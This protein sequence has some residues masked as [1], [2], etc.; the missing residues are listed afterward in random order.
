MCAES[1][2]TNSYNVWTNNLRY[3]LW[4]HYDIYADCLQ[5]NDTVN[6][7]DT[8]DDESW[9]YSCNYDF[10]LLIAFTCIITIFFLIW[11]EFLLWSLVYNANACF[12]CSATFLQGNDGVQQIHWGIEEGTKY[13]VKRC[14]MAG[15]RVRAFVRKYGE[16]P[17]LPPRFILSPWKQPLTT[18]R[19]MA[20]LPTVRFSSYVCLFCNCKI[21]LFEISTLFLYFDFP[22]PFQELGKLSNFLASSYDA[23]LSFDELQVSQRR[24]RV[25][26]NEEIIADSSSLSGGGG[27]ASKPLNFAIHPMELVAQQRQ[28][29]VREIF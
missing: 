7:I 8:Y 26:T 28:F 10:L 3:I 6:T 16:P 20:T 9:E 5:W 27:A 23:I 13:C 12:C 22:F 2:Q 18:H 4:L 15:A 21:N 14:V 24:Y 11:F 1:T 19:S 25:K 29:T 17:C